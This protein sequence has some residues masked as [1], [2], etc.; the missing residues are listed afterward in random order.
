MTTTEV[1]TRPLLEGDEGG[2]DDVTAFLESTCDN[3][4]S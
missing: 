1:S 2:G 4:R 3:D